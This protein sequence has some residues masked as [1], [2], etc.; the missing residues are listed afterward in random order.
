M[1]CMYHI[2]PL[3]NQTMLELALMTYFLSKPLFLDSVLCTSRIYSPQNL[4]NFGFVER[5]ISITLDKTLNK[6]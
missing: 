3:V 4:E 2:D 1:A 5:R 6:K